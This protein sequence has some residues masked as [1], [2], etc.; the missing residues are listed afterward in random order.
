[1]LM[2]YGLDKLERKFIAGRISEATGFLASSSSDGKSTLNAT[3]S[4]PGLFFIVT[5]TSTAAS[6]APIFTVSLLTTKAG[7]VSVAKAMG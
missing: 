4:M 1:M 3:R 2:G 7:A 6:S 5:V